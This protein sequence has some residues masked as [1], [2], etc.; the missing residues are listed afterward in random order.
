M[1]A[2]QPIFETD[3]TDT[4]Q[5][6]FWFGWIGGLA[7][8]HYHVFAD[9]GWILDDE[10]T[11]FWTSRSA[12]VDP[13]NLLSM[14][15]RPGRNIIHFPM[16]VFGLT[17]TRLYTLFLAAIAVWLTW[18]TGKR[19]GLPRVEY[20]PL[21]VLFQPW[22]VELSFPVLTQTPFMLV[23]IA[24][25][26]FHI[27]GRTRLA[28]LCIGFLPLVRHE[29]IALTGAY[30]GLLFLQGRLLGIGCAFLPMLAFNGIAWSITGGIP[31]DIFFKPK[32]TEVYGSGPLWHFVQP[33]FNFAG[34]GCSTLLVIGTRKFFSFHQRHPVLLLYPLYFAVHSI[35]YWKGLFASGGY[36]HFLMPMAPWFGLGALCGINQIHA[37]SKPGRIIESSGTAHQEQ[38][39]SNSGNGS[40]LAD[41]VVASL[42]C[43]LV[44]QAYC[45]PIKWLFFRDR[46]IDITT[47]E[48]ITQMVSGAPLPRNRVERT[49]ESAYVW[50][51]RQPDLADRPMLCNNNYFNVL[52]NAYFVRESRWMWFCPPD[53]LPAG[54][55]YVWEPKYSTGVGR[56]REKFETNEWRVLE[57]FSEEV[58]IYQKI[59]KHEAGNAVKSTSSPESPKTKSRTTTNNIDL[60]MKE[61]S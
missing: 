11:H 34:I 26:Y 40:W 32:P 58:I 24:G 5:R 56:P 30:A 23:W 55:V 15:S 20:L 25:I 37:I 13:H 59:P 46:L 12:W 31:F 6:I 27:T 19:T 2:K 36:Y 22:F 49:I 8:S 29:G 28:A 14:W 52:D 9:T 7:L 44:L 3:P 39:D 50:L 38:P 57:T 54:T 17:A 45:R 10:I 51:K 43:A 18:K 41:A 35:I 33:A 21:L 4:R 53:Q 61:E 48:L 42:L 16:A 47:S 60:R 1:S